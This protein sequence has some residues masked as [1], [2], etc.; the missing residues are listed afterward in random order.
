MSLTKVSIMRK[1]II[2][3]IAAIFYV[4]L[5]LSSTFAQGAAQERVLSN[6]G[7]WVAGSWRIG[8]VFFNNQY[9]YCFADIDNQQTTLRLATLNGE[10]LVGTPYYD[11]DKP[12]GTFEAPPLGAQEYFQ[13]ENDQE[14]W[15]Y[16][17]TSADVLRRGTHIVIDLEHRNSQQAPSKGR[18]YWSLKGSSAAM[19]LA[20]NCDRTKG[21]AINKPIWKGGNK[22]PPRN[23]PRNLFPVI[24]L[25]GQR[26]NVGENHVNHYYF[27]GRGPI[28][29]NRQC[30]ITWDNQIVFNGGCII[31]NR[32][33]PNSF[34]L[35]AAGVSAKVYGYNP[36]EGD[37][38]DGFGAVQNSDNHWFATG[39]LYRQGNCWQNR[40]NKICWQ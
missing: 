32:G 25:T 26:I 28:D 21:V 31:E 17:G 5:S 13:F 6:P 2:T 4:F 39:V 19:K 15:A 35:F 38:G 23:K 14:G 24:N 9:R 29:R 22:Q 30:Q 27:Q 20:E 10:W 8:S 37:G 12:N 34:E 18:Q 3:T 36:G 16:T 33:A 1:T 11:N 7:N 40:A